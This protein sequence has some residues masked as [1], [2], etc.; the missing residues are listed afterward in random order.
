MER[1]EIP[2]NGDRPFTTPA[3]GDDIARFGLGLRFGH[4]PRLD[5]ASLSC[6]G[7]SSRR[8][9]APTPA[10]PVGM[11]ETMTKAPAFHRDPWVTV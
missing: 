7:A 1:A 11:A 2:R 9:A 3:D 4:C 10:Q 8:G 5:Y 6:I